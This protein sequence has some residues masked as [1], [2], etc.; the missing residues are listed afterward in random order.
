MIALMLEDF[1]ESLGHRLHGVAT[2][3]EEGLGYGRDGGFDL[4][5]LDCN[6]GGEPVWPLADLLDEKGVPFILSS[7]GSISAAPPRHAGRPLLEKPYTFGA[8]SELLARLDI[9]VA[10]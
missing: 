5:I 1:L 4:A 10:K 3:V 7:G 2:T 6:L 9:G 8:I